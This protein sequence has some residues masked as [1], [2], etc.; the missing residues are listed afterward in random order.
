MGFVPVGEGLL[1]ELVHSPNW[2]NTR[3]SQTLLEYRIL[4]PE[5]RGSIYMLP[6]QL[7]VLVVKNTSLRLK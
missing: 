6:R 1:N 2:F 4:A 3:E 5:R 7:G